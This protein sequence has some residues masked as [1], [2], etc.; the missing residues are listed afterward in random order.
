MCLDLCE[1]SL[2]Y[3]IFSIHDLSK[4]RSLG[5]HT[6]ISILVSSHEEHM[7]I[8]ILVASHAEYQH[9][10]PTLPLYMAKS[11]RLYLLLFR[12]CGCT[13]NLIL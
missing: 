3:V 4:E 11:A 13:R 7:I 9:S 5:H 2:K 1:E 10:S 8:S 6:I 12:Y